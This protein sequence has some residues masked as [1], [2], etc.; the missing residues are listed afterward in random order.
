MLTDPL[1]V[2]HQSRWALIVTM[3]PLTTNAKVPALDELLDGTLDQIIR[4]FAKD[5]GI[6][7]V[8]LTIHCHASAEGPG[9]T[10]F[11]SYGIAHGDE[12]ITPKVSASTEHRLA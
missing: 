7:G 1:T 12:T 2:P 10:V 8:S 6:P 9:E 5:G 3:A 4:D 11:R